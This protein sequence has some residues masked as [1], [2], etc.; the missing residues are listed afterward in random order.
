MNNKLLS[1]SNYLKDKNLKKEYLYLKK[2]A[3]SDPNDFEE[4]FSKKEVQD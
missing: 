1:L 2:I 4:Y 3:Q